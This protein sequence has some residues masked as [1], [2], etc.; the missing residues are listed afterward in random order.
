VVLA[1]RLA[2]IR[3]VR[4][5]RSAPFLART[6]RLSWLAR[7]QSSRPARPSRSS[8]A[9]CNRCH[10]PAR[11]QSRRRRQ[12]VTPLPQPISWGSSSQAIP[13]R[14]TKRMPVSAARSG[15]RGRPP[16]GFGGSGGSSGAIRVHNSSLTTGLL[17]PSRSSSP[18]PPIRF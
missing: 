17:M 11:C 10:T 7:D 16:F 3:G 8:S 15:T 12:Q 2:P 18:A 1:T 5:G 6:L 4:P 13:L 9:W 14:R